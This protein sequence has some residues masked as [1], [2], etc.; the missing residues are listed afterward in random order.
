MA[1][2]TPANCFPSSHIAIP[3]LS[4]WALTREHPRL[5]PA[6]WGGFLLL[7]LSILTTKQHYLADF[8]G[9][10]GAA[11]IGAIVSMALRR[12]AGTPP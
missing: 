6:R 10:L 5:A 4:L 7:S 3:A 12:R 1:A 9:G 11:A 2:D 8:F